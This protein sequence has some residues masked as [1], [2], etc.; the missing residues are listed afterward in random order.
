MA[1]IR[2]EIT[3]QVLESKEAELT[4]VHANTGDISLLLA[5]NNIVSVAFERKLNFMFWSCDSFTEQGYLSLQDRVYVHKA[6]FSYDFLMLL[7]QMACM[8]GRVTQGGF[9]SKSMGNIQLLMA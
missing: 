2:S 1:V 7:A 4:E 8:R 9:H 5:Q 6:E 3:I